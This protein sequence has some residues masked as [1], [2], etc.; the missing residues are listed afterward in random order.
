MQSQMEEE[1]LHFRSNR[2]DELGFV[3][4][5]DA[6]VLFTRPRNQPPPRPL[7]PEEGP[8]SRLPALYAQL[9]GESNLLVR[10]LALISDPLSLRRLEQ[11]LVWTINTAIIAYGETP[12]DIEYVADI[13]MRVR[14]TISLGLESLLMKEDPQH[15]PDSAGDAGRAVS[16]MKNWS[17]RDLF[18]HGYAATEN[19]QREIEQAMRLPQVHAW[20]QLPEME[21]SDEPDDRLDRAFIHALLG[22]HPLLGGFDPADAGKVR[23]F[24]SIEDITVARERLQRLIMRLNS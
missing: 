14:D 5:D 16:L 21:Q 22:R 13:A 9:L 11:E 18:R 7:E 23:A 2:M 1:G 4:P 10:A 15:Q 24:A 20:R 8:V 3:P 17:M 19:L 6:A 12:R